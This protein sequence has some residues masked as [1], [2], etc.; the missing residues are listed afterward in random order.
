MYI[1]DYLTHAR[2]FAE[3]GSYVKKAKAYV[4]ATP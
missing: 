3:Y 1:I 4:T 2:G